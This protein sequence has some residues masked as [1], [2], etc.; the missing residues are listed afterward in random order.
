MTLDRAREFLAILISMASGYN[1]NS[2]QLFSEMDLETAF[3]VIVGEIFLYK[4]YH[5][6]SFTEA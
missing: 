5:C 6:K 3:A 4:S 2:E 1:R